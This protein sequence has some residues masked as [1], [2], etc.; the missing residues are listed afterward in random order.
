MILVLKIVLQIIAVVL[1]ILISS[2]DY[3]WHDKRTRSFKKG[4]LILFTLSIAFLV[5]SIVLTMIDYFDNNRK[6]A[7]LKDQLSKVQEQNDGLQ[8]GITI[9]SNKSSNILLE[10]RDSFVSILKDQRE[11][12]LDTARRID[13]ATNTLQSGISN[14][15]TKQK[16]LLKQQQIT[17]GNVSGGDSYPYVEVTNKNKDNIW[18]LTIYNR[19]KYQLY[20]VVVA[21]HDLGKER[22]SLHKVIVDPEPGKIVKVGDLGPRESLSDNYFLGQLVLTNENI[23]SYSIGVTARNGITH[24]LIIFQR[25]DGKWRKA[26]RIS[27][28]DDIFLERVDD[29]LP[30]DK[31]GKFNWREALDRVLYYKSR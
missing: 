17:L 16:E 23:Q 11:L 18:D 5:G 28:N 27:K 15:I 6:E 24:Q 9:L 31:D 4:R 19:G 20:D 12:G 14:S 21:I 13:G 10:Q 29:E 30:R 3:I 7:E 2:L 22:D 26:T 8:K 1:A 25:I